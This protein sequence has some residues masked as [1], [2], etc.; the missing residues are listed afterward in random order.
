MLQHPALLRLQLKS[1]PA[2]KK[3]MS[4]YSHSN[5]RKQ[6]NSTESG[7]CENTGQSGNQRIT[8]VSV[9]ASVHVAKKQQNLEA[10]RYGLSFPPR[11]H[12]KEA[13]FSLWPKVR[14]NGPCITGQLSWDGIVVLNTGAFHQNKWLKKK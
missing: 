2:K 4:I 12:M 13:W 14:P 6:V 8:S 9:H 11:V 1:S 7:I 3:Q 5:R 10:L